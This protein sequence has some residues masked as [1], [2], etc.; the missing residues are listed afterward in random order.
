VTLAFWLLTGWKV[1]W[2]TY[3]SAALLSLYAI[4]L[5]AV[6]P[7]QV[8]DD[9]LFVGI[10]GSLLLA[11]VEANIDKKKKGGYRLGLML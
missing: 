2:S 11:N 7:K 5:L 10:F 1:E 9:A 3:A 6:D 8:F 4:A